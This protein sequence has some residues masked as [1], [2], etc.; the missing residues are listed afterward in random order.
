MGAH[1]SIGW[2]EIGMFLGF[3]GLFL[4]VVLTSLT[5]APLVVKSHP[6]LEESLHH[7]V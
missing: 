3:M 4:F 5:K 2:M 7:S 6:Y 1:A